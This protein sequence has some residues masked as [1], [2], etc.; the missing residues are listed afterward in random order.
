MVK[1]PQDPQWPPTWGNK[2]TSLWLNHLVESWQ[3]LGKPLTPVSSS[4]K[5]DL[6][7]NGE[8]TTTSHGG[9]TPRLSV[10]EG[11]DYRA[12]L[13]GLEVSW[14]RQQGSGGMGPQ[15]NLYT[16]F[17]RVFYGKITWLLGGAQHLYFFQWACWGAHGSLHLQMT[18][19]Y[20][21]WWDLKDSIG[22]NGVVVY[23]NSSPTWIRLKYTEIKSTLQ[24]T[25]L[26]HHWKVGKWRLGSGI[27]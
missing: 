22:G 13:S 1:W 4:Y 10:T 6:G 8:T 3:A 15:K 26:S 2:K 9:K 27:C 18:Q 17:Q 19:I 14:R 24:R 16:C 5:P 12:A 21:L 23:S 7:T 20:L 11:S 25:N